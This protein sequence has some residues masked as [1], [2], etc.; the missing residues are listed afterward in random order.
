MHIAINCR[1]LLPGK[2]EGIGRFTDEVVRQLVQQHPEARFS[3]F[4]DRKPDPRFTQYGPNATAYVLHPQARH[5]LLFYLWFEWAVAWKLGRLK[6]DVFFSPDGFLSLR[7]PVPQVPVMHDLAFEHFPLDTKA[8]HI[9]HYRRNMPLYAAKAHS[10]LT[11]SQFVKDDI[12][13]RYQVP[14]AKVQV[15]YNGSSGVFHPIPHSEQAAVRAHYTG[16]QPYWLYA[17]AIQP[18]KNLERLLEA[19]DRFADLVPGVP[20]LLTGRRAWNF[21]EVVRTY[22]HMRHRDRVIFTGWVS[23]EELNRLYASAYALVYVSRFEGFGLPLL[24]AMHSETAVIASS[25]TA[26]PEVTG[27]AALYADPYST[28]SILLAMQQ[29]WQDSALRARLIERGRDRRERFSWQATADKCWQAL[30]VA[31]GKV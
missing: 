19:F 22:Q 2:L 31:A 9:R 18:R 13:A 30:C 8:S 5:P 10:I 3:L 21:D 4:F 1:F 17:G 27:P 14:E 26:M 29:L 7:S 25:T 28:D 20:L 6:P 12:V 16:G 11:V 24:E 15:V 23:D